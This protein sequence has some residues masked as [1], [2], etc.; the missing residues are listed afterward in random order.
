MK[1]QM[2]AQVQ[3]YSFFNLG[4]RLSWVV[5]AT[6]RTLYPWERDPVPIIPEVGWSPATVWTGTENFA[7]TG[8]RSPDRQARSASPYRL[9]YP[10][11]ASS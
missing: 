11:H 4:T 10:T 6:P 1:V 3:F 5:N 9:S 8:I 2:R 7:A